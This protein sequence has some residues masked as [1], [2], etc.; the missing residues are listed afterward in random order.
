[1]FVEGT[2]V[3]R[4]TEGKDRGEGREGGRKKLASTYQ[5]DLYS[6]WKLRGK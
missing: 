6:E 1:M 2:A 3:K 5:C 4:K